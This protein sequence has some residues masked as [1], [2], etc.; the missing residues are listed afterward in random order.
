MVAFAWRGRNSWL[1]CSL[2]WSASDVLE[3]IG[4]IPA[5]RLAS[6]GLTEGKGKVDWSHVNIRDFTFTQKPGPKSNLGKVK[7]LLPNSHD[8]LLHDTFDARRKVFQQSMRAIGYGCV[9]MERP[10]QLAEVLLAVVSK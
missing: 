9:R 3:V 1:K 5:T 8:V 7:F 4:T 6:L 10:Q 2:R